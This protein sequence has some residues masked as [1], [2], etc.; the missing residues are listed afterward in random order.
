MPKYCGEGYW[1]PLTEGGRMM[2]KL[3]SP[4]TRYKV[5]MR[6]EYFVTY[7]NARPKNMFSYLTYD[8]GG[9]KGTRH[10]WV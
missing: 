2:I 10:L 4:T 7:E 5:L 1:G 6:A 9:N 3:L 8:N